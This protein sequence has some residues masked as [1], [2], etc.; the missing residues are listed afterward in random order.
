M[1]KNLFVFVLTIFL[2]FLATFL[3]TPL[4]AGDNMSLFVNGGIITDD[5]LSFDTFLWYGGLNIDVHL[6]DSLMLSPEANIL[7]YKFKFDAFFLEP[8][9][10]LNLKLGTFF[11][12]GG[13]NKYFLISGDSHVSTD[14][15]LKLNAGF[16][17]DS[18]RLRVFANM[19]FDNLFKN[20]L[21]G[22][23]V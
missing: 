9:V 21:V 8:A 17:G 3:S 10:L 1:K 15:G 23:Q 22:I 18:V 13:I 4:N 19:D 6:G 2:F 20:M 5:S 11:V 7:T 14:L 12:G 16:S